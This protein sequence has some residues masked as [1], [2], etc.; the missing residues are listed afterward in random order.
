MEKKDLATHLHASEISGVVVAAARLC[1]MTRSS[2]EV[3]NYLLD[4][5]SSSFFGF[6]S[7]SAFF[8]AKEFANTASP[9]ILVS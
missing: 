5:E 2:Y 4:S 8:T 1:T 9:K 7:P 6:F 3:R